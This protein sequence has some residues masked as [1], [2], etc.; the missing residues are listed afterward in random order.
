VLEAIR[1]GQLR[2]PEKLA[3][4]IQGT[5]RNLI[6]NFL[7]VRSRR[8][9]CELPDAELSGGDLAEE[10]ELAERQRLVRG[11]I[12][13]CSNEDRQILECSLVEGMPLAEIATRLGISH[14]AVRARKS[15]LLKRIIKKIADM[16]QKPFP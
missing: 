13:A 10:V 2:E 9:E 8:S 4:F 16:S 3:A 15:R 7:R 14:D 1:R 6:N 11:E 12:E 5:A